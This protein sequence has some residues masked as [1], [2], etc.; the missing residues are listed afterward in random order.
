MSFTKTVLTNY[1]PF[2]TDN[3]NLLSGVGLGFMKNGVFTAAEALADG[4]TYQLIAKRDVGTGTN[5]FQATPVF[6]KADVK[7]VTV[8][9]YAAGTKGT[10]AVTIAGTAPYIK[11][12]DITDGR[13]K[14]A[15]VTIEGT[16]AQ[17]EAGID[18]IGAKVGT[19]FYGVSA[20]V[21]GAVVT[22]SFP[23][24]K[25]YKVVA[26]DESTLGAVTAPVYTVG[27]AAHAKAVEKSALPFAGVTNIAGPNTD[28]PPST[29]LNA[30]HDMYTI[31]IETA[32]GARLDTH[33]I[34]IFNDATVTAF[35]GLLETVFGVSLLA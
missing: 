35:D 32:V 12:I 33:E 29:V 22:V 16:A 5:L 23:L 17:I 8:K 30:N 24:N 28:I 10:A 13:E 25:L 27:T 1:G 2:A 4:N 9:A 34:V 7:K 31:M 6:K 19:Q 15:M 20:A 21:N 11:L 18:A 3:A 26:N 14:F